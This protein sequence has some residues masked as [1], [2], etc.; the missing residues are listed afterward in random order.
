[1]SRETEFGS[2]EEQPNEGERDE[3]KGRSDHRVSR[4]PLRQVIS[5]L[6]CLKKPTKESEATG[7]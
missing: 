2:A 3:R 7:D 1:M 5:V 6:L 4:P